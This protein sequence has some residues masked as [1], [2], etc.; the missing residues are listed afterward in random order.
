M[1]ELFL[2]LL[3]E[4]TLKEKLM[5]V[6]RFHLEHLFSSVAKEQ[7]SIEQALKANLTEVTKKLEKI[8]EKHYA[9]DE[10]NKETFDKFYSK[11]K[12]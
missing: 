5:K 11:F 3:G 9:L 4:Y 6:C 1:N 8:E 7:V 2:N 12:K 10:M